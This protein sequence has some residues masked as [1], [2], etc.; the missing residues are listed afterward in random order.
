MGIFVLSSEA[1]HAENCFII[2]RSKLVRHR[3]SAKEGEFAWP[4]Y[5]HSV[6]SLHSDDLPAYKY[7]HLPK[8][9]SPSVIQ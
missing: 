9:T 8:V 1:M 3:I 4:E 6:F 2:K 7:F 5:R